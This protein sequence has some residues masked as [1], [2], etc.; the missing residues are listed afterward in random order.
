[1]GAAQR[2]DEERVIQPAPSTSYVDEAIKIAYSNL[3]ASAKEADEKS[4]FWKRQA[5]EL[6]N[7]AALLKV[8]MPQASAGAV[9]IGDW[10]KVDRAT[11][12][13]EYLRQFPKGKKVRISDVVAALTQGG[14]DVAGKHRPDQKDYQK[15][16][17]RNLFITASRNQDLYEYD[18][19]AREIWRI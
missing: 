19:K 11:A 17:E 12:M 4:V 5:E 14:C 18:K 7:K 9:R 1:M 10:S 8:A 13:H 2:L 15:E 3:E 6:R 16:A